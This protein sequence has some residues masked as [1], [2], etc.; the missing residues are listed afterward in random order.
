M[1]FRRKKGGFNRGGIAKVPR[2]ITVWKP[3]PD[4]SLLI[5]ESANGTGKTEASV[6]IVDSPLWVEPR[7]NV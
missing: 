3:R 1:G 7:V 4:S 5:A 2:I 6:Q